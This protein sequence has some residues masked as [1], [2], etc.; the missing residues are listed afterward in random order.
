LA[1]S[2]KF[3]FSP[4]QGIRNILSD[5]AP[6]VA[7]CI[8]IWVAR[9]AVIVNMPL[10]IKHTAKARQKICGRTEEICFESVVHI[11]FMQKPLIFDGNTA[12]ILPATILNTSKH[13]SVHTFNVQLG[14]N[15]YACQLESS[16]I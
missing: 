15:L 5:H 1:G 9:A 13:A 4:F 8:C 7:N 6:I 3:C 14:R 16:Q 10:E 2:D 11:V 12:G